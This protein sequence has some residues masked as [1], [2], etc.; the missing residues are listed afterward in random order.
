MIM[1]RLSA[2]LLTA[3]AITASA[4]QVHVVYESQDYATNFF[5]N[6]PPG[7]DFYYQNQITPG[8]DGIKVFQIHRISPQQYDKNVALI[9]GREISEG[10][11]FAYHD[12]ECI[13][14]ICNTIFDKWTLYNAQAS[15]GAV[16]AY[17]HSQAYQLAIKDTFLFY[18]TGTVKDGGLLLAE[19]EI[20]TTDEFISDLNLF[21]TDTRIVV[22]IDADNAKEFVPYVLKDER[23]YIY[24]DKNIP[25]KYKETMSPF[26]FALDR[27]FDNVSDGDGNGLL[28]FNEMY[29]RARN[30]LISTKSNL[31]PYYGYGEISSPLYWALAPEVG[32]DGWIRA[33]STEFLACVPAVD[34]DAELSI[35]EGNWKGTWDD[36]FTVKKS[37]LQAK[38]KDGGPSY[39]TKFSLSAV[40]P[41][42][43]FV[44]P[45]VYLNRICIPV[46]RKIK[47]SKSSITYT[48]EN[49]EFKTVGKLTIKK[50]TCVGKFSFKDKSFLADAFTFD[51]N[52]EDVQVSFKDYSILFHE[53]VPFDK[54]YKDWKSLTA[55]VPKRK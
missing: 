9:V 48:I 52:S 46:G 55:K 24:C 11:L 17:I 31:D 32:C 30:Y 2:I 16:R 29:Y 44:S 51:S 42:Y 4:Y 21:N 7:E 39:P 19:D 13:S 40:F 35:E 22:I 34:S 41:F 14:S 23:I 54:T 36:L 25:K 20:Y 28:S 38:L 47:E 37:S 10:A 6:V 8:Q 50:K 3:A 5:A 15:K 1:Q 12:M 45:A 27:S 49:Y 26:T 53:L 18:F 33:N 43:S